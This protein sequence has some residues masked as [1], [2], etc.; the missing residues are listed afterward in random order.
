MHLTRQ[1]SDQPVSYPDAIGSMEA[2]VARMIE[3]PLLP[4][5]LW[6]LEHPPL[7]TAG[8][9]AKAQDLLEPHRFPVYPSGRGGEY[10]YHGPGQRVVYLMFRLK[11]WQE[12]PD[13]RAYVRALE[14]WLIQTLAA[15][16][17]QGER[18]EGR[19]GI[20]VTLQGGLE[21]KIAALGIRVRKGIAFHGVA[22]NVAPDLTHFSGI[23][24]C[25]IATHGVTSL[26]ALG[27]TC[28]M[29]AVDRTL[30]KAFAEIFDVTWSKDKA[31][32]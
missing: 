19:V 2:Y 7:Y 18:R 23:V 15:C 4:S 13:I 20:W 25:G 16:G 29:E 21:A 17:V 24:P 10:T 3:D 31:S 9:S 28:E 32:V 8:T 14:A 5:H 30:L 22:L 6:L 12:T 1:K 11:D 27:A 26:K